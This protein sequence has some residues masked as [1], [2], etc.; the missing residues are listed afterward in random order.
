[1]DDRELLN[2]INKAKRDF[3]IKCKKYVGA[4]TVELIRAALKNDN[5]ES[6]PRDVYI[7]EIPFE[8]D[9]LIPRIGIKPENNLVYQIQKLML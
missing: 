2:Q 7:K 9:L 6:S 5:I 1:M 3:G 4:I 8:F